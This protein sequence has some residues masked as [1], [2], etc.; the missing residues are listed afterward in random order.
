[1]TLPETFDQ[2]ASRVTDDRPVPFDALSDSDRRELTAAYIYRQRRG[3]Y[4][5]RL[6]VYEMITEGDLMDEL[7]LAIPRILADAT[8]PDE[9]A[10]LCLLFADKAEEY[11]RP[12]V[13]EA[14]E[15]FIAAHL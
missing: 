8:S 9:R 5:D 4:T 2:V 12:R 13:T 7:V 6:G 3:S 1:M 15:Q 14:F 11:L 10:G